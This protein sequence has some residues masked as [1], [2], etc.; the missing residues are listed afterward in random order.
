MS[1]DL[2]E[3]NPLFVARLGIAL[4]GPVQPK[5]R[6]PDPIT[7]YA[8]KL[9][10]VINK[11]PEVVVKISGSS[12]TPGKT[13]AHLTYIT[14]NGNFEAE[15]E[16]GERI[17]GREQ[18]KEAFGEWGLL[19]RNTTRQRAHSVHVVM[20][21]PEGTSAEAIWNAARGFAAEHFAGNHQYLMVLHTDTAHPHVHVAVRAQGFDLTWLKR[22]KAD[23]HEWRESFAQQMRD[24][25]VE[26]E[27]TPRRSRGVVQKAKSQAMHHLSKTPKRSK[28]IGQKVEEAIR[29]L[30]GQ[31]ATEDRPWEAALAVQ[32]RRVRSAYAGIAGD[33]RAAEEGSKQK[34][35][36]KLSVFLANMPP[37]ETERDTL[38]RKISAMGLMPSRGKRPRTAQPTEV[39]DRPGD[40]DRQEP[41]DGN[42]PNV[43][44]PADRSR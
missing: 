42:M 43:S 18:V 35:A 37:L 30:D 21:M 38:K 6:R 17:L 41:P 16:R 5:R 1:A 2:P 4:E 12:G 3:L 14:R 31:L 28:V 24:Q 36:D 40:A 11:A 8:G 26:A 19:A 20:S 27:A 32:Q 34:V 15:N 25:G 7:T 13:L 33:L 39:R 9:K 23:L 44:A 22:S 10:R 29:E